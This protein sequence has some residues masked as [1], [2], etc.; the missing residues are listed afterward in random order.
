M[1]ILAL[2]QALRSGSGPLH[3]RN[4]LFEEARA[5]GH[6]QNLREAP[7]YQEEVAYILAESH[8]L[9]NEPI[10]VLPFSAFRQFDTTGSRIEYEQHYFARRKRLTLLVLA[11]LLEESPACL[12][13]IEDTIW[14]ICEEYTWCLPAH[15]GGRSLDPRDRDFRYSID[16]FAAETGFALAEIISLLHQPLHPMIVHRAEEEV[17]KRI[18]VPYTS[19]KPSYGWEKVTSNWASVCAG[20]IGSAA[21]YLLQHESEL[22]SL[23]YRVSG[24]LACYISGFEEDGACTEGVGYWTYGF[25]FYAYFASLLKQRTGGQIDLM[26]HP[27]VRNIARF[28]QKSYLSGLL[29]VPFSDCEP[30]GYFAPGL[31][32]ELHRQDT[33][34]HI[35]EWRHRMTLLKDPLGRWAPAVRDLV[36]GPVEATGE[37][38]PDTDDLLPD[39]QW[40]VSRRT[41]EGFRMA[42]AAKGGHN[43]E[44]HN[45]ND[46]GNFVLHLD[47]ETFV[48]DIGSGE[49]TKSYFGAERYSYLCNGAH[50]HSI[51][52]LDGVEQ[53]AGKQYRA[54]LLSTAEDAAQ[55]RFRLD[56]T[57]AYEL[58]HLKH[59]ARSFTFQPASQHLLELRDLCEFH[60]A[61]TVTEQFITMIEPVLIQHGC[62]RIQGLKSHIDLLYDAALFY[63]SIQIHDF[64]NKN[65]ERVQVY[66]IVLESKEPSTEFNINLQ[67]DY[68]RHTSLTVREDE[69]K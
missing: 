39:A 40:Y 33:E 56:L 19:P 48:A 1:D 23:L 60:Q 38:W 17:R 44:H 35:P 52:R 45:H 62:V 13:A 53:Q 29:T 46:I 43:D 69:F 7:H 63:A 28:H 66:A 57:S 49:Y 32:H 14:A 5:R 3:N 2:K 26:K 12:T 4:T 20:S 21:L 15:M 34:I 31:I 59:F 37:D 36:W 51:P 22:A 10:P 24:T 55:G 41:V 68:C 11:Y 64:I 67:F 6:W 30:Q 27:K 16:L 42:F 58:E 47:G 8:R 25:G 65:S 9:M 18:F 50:G 54:E 61:G